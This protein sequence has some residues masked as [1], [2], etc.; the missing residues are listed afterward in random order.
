MASPAL[1][2]AV[3]AL[4]LLSVAGCLSIGGGSDTTS[5]TSTVVQPT[6]G[7]QLVDLKKALDTGA[8][9]KE[10]YETLRQRILSPRP[11]K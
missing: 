7:Q 6:I 11:D 10:E 4:L 3:P 2:R 8:V 1:R 5:T 9:S